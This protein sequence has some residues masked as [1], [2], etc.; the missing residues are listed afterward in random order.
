VES[1]AS[2]SYTRDCSDKVPNL[3]A[4]CLSG[5]GGLASLVYYK[6]ST[7]SANSRQWLLPVATSS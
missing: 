2:S 5:W 1:D 4:G 7:S 3:A 6:K